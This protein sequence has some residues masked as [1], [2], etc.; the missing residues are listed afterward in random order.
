MKEADGRRGGWLR[1]S[2]G[3]GLKPVY[4]TDG[5]RALKAAPFEFHRIGQH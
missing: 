4:Y 5:G 2:V 3:L 1:N